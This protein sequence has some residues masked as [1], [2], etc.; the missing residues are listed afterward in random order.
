MNKKQLLLFI[1]PTLVAVM[2]LILLL[3]GRSGIAV[4]DP[5]G[6]IA[7]KERGLITIGSFLALLI[8]VPVFILTFF[9]AYK[10]REGNEKAKYTPD[11]DHNLLLEIAWWAI[12][13]AIIFILA[14]ITWVSS[15][16]LDPFKP[17]TSSTKPITIQVVAL[18][19]RWLFIYPQQNIATLDYVE[20]PQNTPVDFEITSDAPM[21]SFWI[22]SLGGQIYAMN[23]M[24]TQLHLLANGVGTYNGS[25]A[26]ISGAGFSEMK[27]IAQSST[28][29]EFETWVKQV[30]DSSNPLTLAKYDQISKPTINTGQIL[31]SSV[32]KNL[33]HDIVY[34]Y[35]IPTNSELKKYYSSGK[36]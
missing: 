20:F 11:Q 31:F 32:D 5:Q 28:E 8:V 14:A 17:L 21:N 1:I 4:L 12:P 22:P 33:Y 26:N 35:L 36:Y 9:I 16:Q 13:C 7:Q 19:W 24:T 25:S 34:K 2:L 10:Y 27:F 6:L 30:K 3:L 18:E 23:G 29:Q 15:H